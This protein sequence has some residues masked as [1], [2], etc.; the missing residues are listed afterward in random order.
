M[1][2]KKVTGKKLREENLRAIS[3]MSPSGVPT[4]ETKFLGVS[5]GGTKPTL[6]PTEGATA[7]DIG[8]ALFGKDF[9]IS[10]G[11]PGSVGTTKKQWD[12]IQAQAGINAS[13]DSTSSKKETGPTAAEIE[14]E[15]AA[16]PFA[17]MGQ[18]LVKGLEAQEAPVEQAV[19]GALTQP[20]TQSAL[21]T[22]FAAAGLSPT[23]AAGQLVESNIAQGEKNE[24]PLQQAMAA[25]GTAFDSGQK[26]VDQ[27]L[28]NLGQANALGVATAPEQQW[29]TG[30][31]SHIQE[32]L[33]YYG[34]VPGSA[35]ETLPPALQYYLQ[36]SGNQGAA[37]TV[38]ISSI[39]FPKSD[40][41]LEPV[42]AG[43]AKT[44]KNPLADTAGAAPS[45]TDVP[46]DTGSAPS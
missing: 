18:G 15:I 42:V 41:S 34:T 45:K 9:D 23:S 17:Q 40:T 35:L 6:S 24:Q 44:A 19:S 7:D 2:K 5:T 22:A 14:K 16:N 12:E 10:S 26:T 30:L 36:Q 11:T 20:A 25:Y 32:A 37:G 46:T 28:T 1:A 29:L 43:A 8:K 3:E 31:Q 4:K 13:K 39:T 27:A 21:Q 33:S 38:P